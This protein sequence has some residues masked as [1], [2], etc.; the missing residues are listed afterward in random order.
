MKKRTFL[1]FLSIL[2]SVFCLGSFVGC[3]PAAADYDPLVSWNDCATK[4]TIV[5]FVEDVTNPNSDNYV[6]PSDRIATFDNDGTLWTEKPEYI[7]ESFIK[8]RL[9]NALPA[10]QKLPSLTEKDVMVKD[11]TLEYIQ[12]EPLTPEEYKQKARDF[13]DNSLHPYLGVPYIELT[14]QP[15]VELVNYLQS[16]DFKVYICSGGGLDFIRSFAEDA[17]GIPPENVIGTTVQTEYIA[18]G[19]GSYLLVRKPE[20]VQPINDGPGKPV[21]IERYIGKK[22]I[23]AVGNSS[24]DLQMLDYT[25][26]HIGPALMVLLH[27]DDPRE[28]PYAEEAGI[29]CPYDKKDP[30]DIN[31]FDVANQRG[32]TVISMKDDFVTVYGDITPSITPL[33]NVSGSEQASG[34][35]NQFGYRRRAKYQHSVRS[36]V[37]GRYRRY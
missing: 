27:H 16:N 5:N 22:P 31:I 33:E 17:Y 12:P 32:W 20:L 18:Q 11:I 30:E 35:E 23:M 4:Q 29:D 1:V 14:Y 37:A 6:P 34:Y 15:M 19:D 2:L 7:Q 28:C 24:G 21:G 9:S 36:S 3:P 10:L 8:Y 25:D 13:L 26:D